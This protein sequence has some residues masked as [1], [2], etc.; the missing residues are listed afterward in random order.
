M[1]GP[2]DDTEKSHEAT[3]RKLEQARKKGEVPRSTDL[4]VAASYG[5]LLLAALIFGP[6][7]LM[8]LG[9][10]LMILIDQAPTLS[11]LVFE[12]HAQA[13]MGG[14]MMQ[15]IG[16]ISAW[17]I[18]PA[19][20]VLLTIIAQ[21]A[22]LV[23]PDKLKLKLSRISPVSNAKNKYGRNGLFE[24]AKS[25]AKLLIYSACLALFLHC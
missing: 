12:D 11:K 3:P 1:S 18:L 16:S 14:V 21:R 20:V 7:S 6:N 19:T 24:F 9:E 5:G 4:S 2:D 17:F 22:F 10:G 15:T 13:P 8:D 25:F 23:T